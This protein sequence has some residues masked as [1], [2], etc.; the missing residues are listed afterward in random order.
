MKNDTL[1]KDLY[2]LLNIV[3]FVLAIF[4]IAVHTWFLIDYKIGYY[5]YNVMYRL[6]VP[7]FF[8]ASGFL[9]AKK[10]KDNQ[11]NRNTIFKDFFKRN[12][13][14]YLYLSCMYMV[15]NLIKANN[16][17]AANILQNIWQI[18]IGNSWSIAWF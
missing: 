15:I 18:L 2:P 11:Q 9:L 8:T 13:I 7:F 6:G 17:S 5:L 3:K 14:I 16:F 10:V 1:N 4:I 12:V